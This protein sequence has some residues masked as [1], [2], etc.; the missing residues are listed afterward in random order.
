VKDFEAH[1]PQDARG[2]N[3]KVKKTVYLTALLILGGCNADHSL[4]QIDQDSGPGLPASDVAVSSADAWISPQ[5]DPDAQG[6]FLSETNGTVQTGPNSSPDAGVIG[7]PGP[8]QSWTGYVENYQFPSGSDVIRFTVAAD[9][10]GQVV[11]TTFLGNGTPPAPATDPNVGYPPDFAT[12]EIYTSGYWVEGFAYSM[13]NG[14]LSSGRLRFSAQ[15][16]GLWSEWCA[17]QTPVEGSSGCVRNWQT[18][19]NTIA[20]SCSQTNPADGQS[21]IVDWG[22]F[23][24]CGMSSSVCLCS[25]T[26]CIADLSA[27]GTLDFD[28]ALSGTDAS[29]STSGSLGDHNVHFTK[30]P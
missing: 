30:D 27:G 20:Q 15:S 14:K 1:T 3:G 4:G 25:T 8:S 11:G 10:S 6:S 9:S 18:S 21:I 2:G 29:G 7:Q 17:L 24:L 13:A 26:A 5:V 28:L 22:K 16:N 12:A 19:C 23:Q